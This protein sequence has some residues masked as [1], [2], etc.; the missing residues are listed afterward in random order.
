MLVSRFLPK[1]TTFQ[2]T[3]FKDPQ[4][5]LPAT[6]IQVA[7]LAST[8]PQFPTLVLYTKPGCP[9]CTRLEEKIQA[10][11][12]RA[13]FLPSPLTSVNFEVVDISSDEQLLGR[14]EM[15]VPVVGRRDQAGKEEILPQFSPRMTA[16]RLGTKLEPFFE[17]QANPQ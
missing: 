7:C 8:K 5:R 12:D 9:L 13:Q 2:S 17:E 14:Y 10:L 15:R 4:R 3:R 16:E 11:L 6:R 1:P